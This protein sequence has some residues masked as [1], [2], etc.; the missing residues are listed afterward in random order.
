VYLIGRILLISLVVFLFIFTSIVF[1]SYRLVRITFISNMFKEI[2]L[3]GKFVV[4][5]MVLL[6][7]IMI[8]NYISFIYFRVG[9]RMNYGYVFLYTVFLL[10][11]I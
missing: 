1:R 4:S 3:V 2:Y 11:V 6:I 7:G 9:I 5:L 8:L 10:L